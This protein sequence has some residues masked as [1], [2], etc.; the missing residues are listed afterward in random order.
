MVAD[1]PAYDAT[2]AARG[3]ADLKALYAAALA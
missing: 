2:A 1:S 3:E